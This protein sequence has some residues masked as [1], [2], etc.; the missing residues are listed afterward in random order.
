MADNVTHLNKNMSD[1]EPEEK[2]LPLKNVEI[3]LTMMEHALEKGSSP[4]FYLFYGESGWGKTVAANACVLDFDAVYVSATPGM[5]ARSLLREL[6]EQMGEQ[7]KGKS[8]HDF[9]KQASRA[10][11]MTGRAL[12][13]DEADFLL[14]RGVIETLR[15]VLDR[16][17]ARI[18]LIGEEEIERRLQARERVHNRINGFY[19]AQPCSITDARAMARHYAAGVD[20]AADLLT[21]MLKQTNGATRRV[22]T[23]LV[24]MRREALSSGAEAIDLNWW[25]EGDRRFSTGARPARHR[26][27]GAA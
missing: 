15:A 19:P 17:Q 3:A 12:I 2:T 6:L 21:E 18:I 9:I 27:G 7:P 13:V 8:N 23:N 26:K 11:L 10:L 24:E 25:R 1:V 5:S 20:I 14:K 16:S 22:R 4:G